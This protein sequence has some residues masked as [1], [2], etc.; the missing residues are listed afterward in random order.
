MDTCFGLDERTS[1]SHLPVDQLDMRHLNDGSSRVETHPSASHDDVGH[2]CGR[3]GC[4]CNNTRDRLH[5]QCRHV[6]LGGCLKNSRYC[7]ATLEPVS[8]PNISN[9]GVTLTVDRG[10]QR[11]AALERSIAPA[12][13]CGN[14][15]RR[16]GYQ[17]FAQFLKPRDRSDAEGVARLGL[18][19]AKA[20][21]L[22]PIVDS[23]LVQMLSLFIL[24]ETA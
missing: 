3:G 19:T 17:R 14:P 4:S 10:C 21:V 16:A 7:W 22:Q 11:A 20:F 8:E 2:I 12:P 9:D 23:L 24:A 18:S 1:S 6:F 5:D 13:H 15:A